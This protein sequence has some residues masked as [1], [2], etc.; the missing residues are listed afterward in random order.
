VATRFDLVRAIDGGREPNGDSF[1]ERI[2][3]WTGIRTPR[4]GAPPAPIERTPRGGTPISP[5][6]IEP[7]IETLPWDVTVE[8]FAPATEETL[9]P[10]A[11]PPTSGTESG[12]ASGSGATAGGSESATP[13]DTVTSLAQVLTSLFQ[14]R[15]VG[16]GVAPTAYAPLDIQ[17]GSA[18]PA[19]KG[20]MML[21]VIAVAGGAF[22]LWKRGKKST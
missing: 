20:V 18:A 21:L 7:H 22:Y 9:T 2:G 4:G 12:E 17:T 14:P 11:A 6:A 19:S 13:T 5:V 3:N 15:P 10:A 8:Y 1:A 16:G